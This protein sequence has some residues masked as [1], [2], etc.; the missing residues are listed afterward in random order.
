MSSYT[1]LTRADWEAVADRMLLAV[2]PYASPGHALIDLPGPASRSGRRSDGLEGFA[3][4]FLL[5]AFRLAGSGGADPLGLAGWYAEGLA[6]GTDPASP[7]RWPRMSE[8]DQAKVEAASLVIALHETRPWIWDRLDPGVRERVLDW[9]GDMTGAWVPDCNWVWF[10]AIVAAFARSHGGRWSAADI[11][12]AAGLTEDW[13]AGDGWYSDG[14]PGPGEFR[15]FDHYNGWAMHLYPLWF[16]RVAGA[17]GER[18]RDRLRRFLT[19]AE[20]LVG[21]D[22]APLFQG[23][24]LTYRFAALAPFWAG[25]IFDATPLPPGLTRRIASG[26]LRYFTDAGCLSADGRLSLGWFGEFL[27]IRQEYSGPGS[28]YWASKGFAGLLLPP[29]HP[30]WTAPEEPVAVE[31]GD[32]ERLISPPG[33]LVSGTRSDGIVRVVNHGTDHASHTPGE[34]DDPFYCRWAYSTRTGPE[35]G[36]ADAIDS[37]VALVDADGR[38]SHRRPLVRA[39]A[40]ASRHRAHWP[41]AGVAGPPAGVTGP[42]LTTASVLRGPWEV[43]AVRVEPGGVPV[44]V[45][46]RLGGWAV[47]GG[48]PPSV[49]CDGGVGYARADGGLVSVVRP[50]RGPWVPAVRETAGTSAFGG[51]TAVP[52]LL[53]PGPVD[54]GQVCVAAIYL[55]IGDDA[56]TAPRA[57]VDETGRVSVTWASGA[58]DDLWPAAGVLH[59]GPVLPV[60]VAAD[61]DPPVVAAA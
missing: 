4:T 47:A 15:N 50:L 42:W 7:L 8:T 9:L 58:S 52:Y 51:Y 40:G 55:G 24:S 39:G 29:E 34:P 10:Q 35:L 31:R 30:V 49:R 57:E 37:T 19:D 45:R 54:P 36:V 11:E 13:Y 32:F 6:T 22:G 14:T 43:R 20:H 46:L 2:R 1:G 28:P 12:R 23:R 27:P 33:W 41:S 53:S 25:V 48:E 38:A 61:G 3:R 5:A 59:S 44:G 16:C 21:G 17:D 56:A 26:M 18:Y 60:A